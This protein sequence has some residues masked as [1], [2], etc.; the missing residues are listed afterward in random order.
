MTSREFKVKNG[1]RIDLI[2]K[3]HSGF[4]PEEESRPFSI[5]GWKEEFDRRYASNLTEQEHA[6]LESLGEEC[7]EYVNQ[8]YPLR[9]PPDMI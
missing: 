2:Q 8:K 4:T 1:R 9:M 5:P 7:S 6:E 3:A